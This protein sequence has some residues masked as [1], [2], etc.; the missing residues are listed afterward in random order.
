MFLIYINDLPNVTNK[1]STI[2]YADDSN[3]FFS[4]HC[5]AQLIETVNRELKKV[6]D[7]L[8]T[9]KLTLDINKSKYMGFFSKITSNEEICINSKS[10]ERVK[11]I[12]FLGFYLDKK[13]TWKAH[14]EYNGIKL[15]NQ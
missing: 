11:T 3:F 13:L 10:L 5:K 8:C 1:P 6:Y 15:P 9:N 7:W 14:I 2:L 4:H 12:K